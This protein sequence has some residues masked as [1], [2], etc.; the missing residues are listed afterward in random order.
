M[1]PPSFEYHDPSRLEEALELLGEHGPEAKVLAG[2]QSLVPLLNL[3]LVT[4][5]RLVDVNRIEALAFVERRDRTLAL[6]ATTRQAVLEHSPLVS[7][8]WPLLVEAVRWVAH[9]QVRNRGTVGGSLAN[10]DP[11]AELIAACAALDAR[12]KA[13]SS[14]AARTITWRDFFLARLTQ[15][16]EPDEL[17]TEIEVPAPP[18]GSGS[19]FVE[20]APRRGDLALGGAA[21]VVTLAEDGVCRRAAIALLGA[22]DVP[23]RAAAAESALQG[24]RIDR[25]TA[26][27][28]SRLAIADIR[29]SGNVHGSS[30]YRRQLI[31]VMVARGL[32]TAAGRA[33]GGP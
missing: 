20:F 18:P 30:E 17:L 31:G 25:A 2:G 8:G 23:V 7:G 32:L 9:A 13:R 6:G 33:T 15:A 14:R 5:T 4:P 11:A 29:P 28:A 1:K 21:V 26:G 19:A 12:V 22:G 3:R 27:E 10:A 16:L 24:E